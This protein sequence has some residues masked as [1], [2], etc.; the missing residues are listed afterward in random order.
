MKTNVLKATAVAPSNI[1][2]IKYW[3]RGSENMAIND[4][5]SMNLDSCLTTTTVEFSPQLSSDDVSFVG[6]SITPTEVARVT[7]YLDKIRKKA[8]IN[9]FAKVKT[10]NSF[11]KSAGIASSASGFAALSL[12]ASTAANMSLSEKDLS[13]MARYGSGSASRSIPDGFVRWYAGSTNN[14][15]FASSL[16][17]AD[18]WDLRDVIIIVSKYEKKDSSSR[19]HDLATTSPYFQKRLSVLPIRLANIEKALHDRNFHLLGETI[20][21]E[22]VDLHAIAMTS[23][24]PLFYWDG[25]TVEIIKAV[26]QWRTQGMQCYFT[27]DAGSTVHIITTEKSQVDI[28]KRVNTLPFEVETIT[29]KPFHGARVAADHLF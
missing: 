13:I 23:K 15:S 17:P 14:T 5:I 26:R 16:Y 9:L 3:G 12:A 7:Q 2:F 4:S 28:L 27:M 25:N 1:A 8:K 22:T 10:K 29:N 24:P 21:E 19:G 18:W 11:P 6:L 20:E